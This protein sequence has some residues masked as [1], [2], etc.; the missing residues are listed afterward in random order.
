M[1]KSAGGQTE[2]LARFL[3]PFPL[4][5]RWRAVLAVP[6]SQ[7]Y[8]AAKKHLISA[9][10]GYS[11]ENHFPIEVNIAC[12]VHFLDVC[13]M[14]VADFLNVPNTVKRSVHGDVADASPS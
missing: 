3:V 1:E 8:A 11:N 7:C 10:D 6:H 9:S 14:S 4:S 2:L 12:S 5:G 13:C